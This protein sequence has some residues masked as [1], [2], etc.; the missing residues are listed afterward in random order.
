MSKIREHQELVPSVLDRL[1]N[2]DPTNPHD[3]PKSRHQILSEMKTSVRRDLENLLN[4]RYRCVNWPPNLEQLEMSLI[5]YGLPDFSSA[6]LG[7][8]QDRENLRQI[9]ERVIRYFEPRFK[10][11]S[12]SFL[13]EDLGDRTLRLRIDAMLFAEPA[14]EPVVFDSQLETMSRTFTVETAGR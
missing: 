14:P 9:V 8:K 6:Q 5:N 13:S 3:A 12:V 11:V 7:S 10:T 4:T 2:D 1:L